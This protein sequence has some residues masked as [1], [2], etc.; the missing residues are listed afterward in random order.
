MPSA[1]AV[2]SAAQASQRG[3]RRPQDAETALT[4]A[5]GHAGLAVAA[6]AGRRLQAWRGSLRWP[7]CGSL[8]L[9]VALCAAVPAWTLEDRS[10]AG[11]TP[12]ALVRR[13]PHR[14][15]IPHLVTLAQLRAQ[16]EQTMKPGLLQEACG[17]ADLQAGGIE[18]LQ[19]P[20]QPGRAAWAAQ[21]LGLHSHW[22]PGASRV[23]LSSQRNCK[24]RTDA[25]STACSTPAVLEQLQQ[26]AAADLLLLGQADPGA[27]AQVVQDAAQN[28]ASGNKPGFFNFFA[29]TFEVVLKAR[30]AAVYLIESL[31]FLR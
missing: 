21:Q 24:L 1:A 23:L 28:T 2:L 25:S 15:L 17:S 14:L 9:M 27:A 12:P 18:A 7:C 6:H 30:P 16:L 31:P 4:H 13:P 20:R 22:Q 11:H 3:T 26:R 19:R 29:N 8:A 5:S 10:P